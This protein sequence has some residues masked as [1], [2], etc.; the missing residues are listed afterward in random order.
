MSSGDLDLVLYALIAAL[1]PLGAAA[2]LA[3]IRTGRWNALAF[4]IGLVSSQTL[5]CAALVLIGGVA[6]PDRERGHPTFRA[7]LELGFGLALLWLAVIVRR[8][9]QGTAPRSN[10]RAQA[11]LE[12][13][14]RLRL[15]T[16]LAA[17]VLLG[18]GGPKRL[19]LTALAAASIAASGSEGTTQGALVVGYALVATVLVWAPILAYELVG[20]RVVA[21]LDGAQR[22]LAR[23]QRRTMFYALVVIGSLSLVDAAAALRLAGS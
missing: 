16:A 15:A 19:V 7:L 11:M 10:G 3:V 6:A 4:A 5:A 17:G 18:I 9:P 14:A 1:S 13:L 21:R 20:D 22:W 23:R 8:Q 2:T 12:R